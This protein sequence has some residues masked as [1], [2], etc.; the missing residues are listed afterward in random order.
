M[1]CNT[2]KSHMDLMESMAGGRDRIIR[3]PTLVR[4][5]WKFFEKMT[6]KLKPAK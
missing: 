3:V 6:F 4:E 2:K 1:V 5:S